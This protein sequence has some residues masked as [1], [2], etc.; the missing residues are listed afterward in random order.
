MTSSQNKTAKFVAPNACALCG[1]MQR[2]H[3]QRFHREIGEWGGW[4]A[5]SNA[6]RL[7]RMK[8]NRTLGLNH[9]T[10]HWYQNTP[11]SAN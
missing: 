11:K 8:M 3:G 2:F 6:L 4:I 5:P 1:E 10:P 9:T 7:E